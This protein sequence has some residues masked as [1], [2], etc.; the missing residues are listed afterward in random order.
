[1]FKKKATLAILMATLFVMVAPLAVELI[2]D[3]WTC[4]DMPA[5]CW[6]ITSRGC[7]GDVMYYSG[8]HMYC[9]SGT[10]VTP[11]VNCYYPVV[12]DDPVAHQ[13]IK[14]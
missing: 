2:A 6:N 7:S 8:C 11:A 10:T 1:M 12:I 14:D 13:L 3:T 9:K 4:V 5:N